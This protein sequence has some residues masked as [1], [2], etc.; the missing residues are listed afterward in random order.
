VHDIPIA[1]APMRH[2]S[3]RPFDNIRQTGMTPNTNTSNTTIKVVP[4]RNSSYH[5]SASMVPS[6]HIMGIVHGHAVQSTPRLGRWPRVLRPSVVFEERIDAMFTGVWEIVFNMA[7]DFLAGTVVVFQ[8]MVSGSVYG[9]CRRLY[10]LQATEHRNFHQIQDKGKCDGA[11]KHAAQQQE[12]QWH[13]QPSNSGQCR[14]DHQIGNR[15]HDEPAA[16]MG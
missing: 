10:N 2:F 4:I 9:P 13:H 16:G 5:G 3:A 7:G 8:S 12:R 6:K 15:R 11:G 1:R 14:C